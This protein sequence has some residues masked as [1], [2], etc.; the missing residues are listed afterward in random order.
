THREATVTND[1]RRR[2]KTWLGSTVSRRSILAATPL[3]AVGGLSLAGCTPESDSTSL[4]EGDVRAPARHPLPPADAPQTLRFF[5]AEEARA[6]EAVVSRLMPDDGNGPGA[7]QAGVVVYIDA[8]LAQF[9]GFPDPAY[10]APPF[11][12]PDGGPGIEVEEDQLYRY[13][14]QSP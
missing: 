14:Y 5:T 9:E 13:G 4:A 10:H 7:A 3:A 2:R 12:A 6:V 1:E 11:A 8:K